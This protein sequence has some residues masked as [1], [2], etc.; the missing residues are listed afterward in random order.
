MESFKKI[1][2]DIDTTAAAH[3]ALER[4]ILLAKRSRAPDCCRRNDGSALR[5]SLFTARD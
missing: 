5:A 3:P 4:A 1:L 2:V